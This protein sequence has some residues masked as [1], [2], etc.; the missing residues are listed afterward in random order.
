MN[1]NGLDCGTQAVGVAAFDAAGAVEVL[2][3][4]HQRLMSL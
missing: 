3:S 2:R 4:S 1:Q